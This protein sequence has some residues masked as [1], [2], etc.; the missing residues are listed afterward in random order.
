MTMRRSLLPCLL[1][2]FAVAPTACSSS[3]AADDSSLLEDAPR[4]W[5]KNFAPLPERFAATPDLANAK[6][7]ALGKKIFFEAGLVS[8]SEQKSCAT[9][10]NIPTGA[11]SKQTS[12][13]NGTRNSPTVFNAAGLT[14]STW[15]AK[16]QTIEE[17]AEESLLD[18]DELAMSNPDAVAVRLDE[19]GYQR[20]FR[21]TFDDS[22]PVTSKN[23]GIALGAYMRTLATSG[24][25]FDRYLGGDDTALSTDEIA[26]GQTFVNTGC[27]NCHSGQSLGG[28][29]FTKLAAVTPNDTDFGRFNSTGVETERWVF[30]SAPLRNVALTAPY[31]H[32]GNVAT[33]EQATRSMAE[34][35]LGKTLPDDD[36][37]AI[38][39]FLN[40]LSDLRESKLLTRQVP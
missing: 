18:A 3:R 11:D 12:R 34:T 32:K 16:R 20:E 29:T 17:K 37:R 7:V 39:I 10:H 8:E 33:L 28:D 15:E 24:G 9:C 40:A 19:L 36:V 31:F 21:D 2:A 6:R 23:A 14:F 25:R 4:S 38:V 22:S 35:Q 1:F 13:P 26:G 30:R 5:T 27:G